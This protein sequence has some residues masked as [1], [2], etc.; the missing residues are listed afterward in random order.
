[1]RNERHLECLKKWLETSEKLKKKSMIKKNKIVYTK[2][3]PQLQKQKG[4]MLFTE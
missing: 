4:V 3:E 1:M 2:E